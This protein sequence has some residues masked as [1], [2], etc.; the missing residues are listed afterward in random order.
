MQQIEWHAYCTTCHE[1]IYKAPN[2][3]FVEAFAEQHMQKTGH[4]V[5]VGYA[6]PVP[7]SDGGEAK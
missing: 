1:V 3:R 6:P 5:I 7:K 2:G 4:E